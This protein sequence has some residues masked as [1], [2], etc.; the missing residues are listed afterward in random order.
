MDDIA[1][2]RRQLIDGTKDVR[3]AVLRSGALRATPR[4]IG[5]RMH[6]TPGIARSALAWE[7]RM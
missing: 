5:N 3:N 7:S 4:H 2:G 1:V 6:P